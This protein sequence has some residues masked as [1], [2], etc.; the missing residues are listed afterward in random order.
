MIARVCSPSPIFPAGSTPSNQAFHVN[1][2]DASSNNQS[3]K[4]ATRFTI[5][6]AA[7]G[8][9]NRFELACILETR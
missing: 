1:D 8:R 5:S 7:L 2:F 4:A 6:C 9:P 3:T